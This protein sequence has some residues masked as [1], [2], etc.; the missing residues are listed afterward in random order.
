MNERQR[1]QDAC[2][3]QAMGRLSADETAW[4]GQTLKAHP[5]WESDVDYANELVRQSREFITQHEAK[6]APMLSF[7]EVMARLPVAKSSPAAEKTIRLPTVKSKA[8]V[9]AMLEKFMHWWS[10]P[11]AVGL[12]LASITAL[13]VGLSVQTYRVDNMRQMD[14]ETTETPTWGG[15][16]RSGEGLDQI[17]L[18]VRFTAEAS[19]GQVSALL[20]T[21]RLQI[22]AGPD[23]DQT[24]LLQAPA[25][26]SSTT[27]TT[28]RGSNLVI[29]V[30]RVVEIK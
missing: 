1:F 8:G 16:Y 10:Q 19:L 29:S 7:E 3:L 2:L 24:Y 21:H 5:D 17:T 23:N 13:A 14:S 15:T 27:V 9:P 20:S 6:R 18:A 30:T 22:V 26:E 25:A 12:V 28:L 4:L 11:S